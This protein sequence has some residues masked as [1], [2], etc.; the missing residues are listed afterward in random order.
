MGRMSKMH[1]VP[2]AELAALV[3]DGFQG[4]GLGTELYRRLLHIAADEKL[5]KVHSNM[6][7]ENIEMKTICKSLG[8]KM[9]D[10]VGEDNLV[11]AELPL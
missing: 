11:L 4:K 3:R 9:T 5:S 6:L 10:S 8:F 2:E 7:G 1:G